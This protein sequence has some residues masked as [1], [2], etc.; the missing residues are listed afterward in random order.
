MKIK[1]SMLLALCLGSVAF[2]AGT[3]TPQ[4]APAPT[5]KTLDEID[6]SISNTTAAVKIA[7]PRTPISSTPYSITKSGSYYLTKNLTGGALDIWVDNVTI[8]LKGF[9]IIRSGGTAISLRG[10]TKK[11]IHVY[12]GTISAP[13][14]NGIDFS[15]SKKG[16]NGLLENL[17]VYDCSGYGIAVGS[18]FVIRK[19]QV[20]NAQFGIGVYRSSTVKDCTITG[21]RSSGLSTMGSGAYIANN[22]VKENKNNYSFSL[23]NHLNLV[24]SEVP[25]SLDWPCSVR[26]AG[27]LT[28]TNTDVDG[29]TINADNITI[30]MAG[31]AL[32]G[33]GTS[34]KNGIFQDATFKNLRVFNG[35]ISNWKGSIACGICAKGKNNILTNI[36]A[37]ENSTGIHSS[38]ASILSK[39]AAYKNSSSGISCGEGSTI[40]HCTA[41]KNGG[42]GIFSAKASTVS[43]CT[44]HDNG[45][46]GLFIYEGSTLSKCTAY[47]NG[48]DG[49]QAKESTITG[50]TSR[51]NKGDGIV[52]SKN[53]LVKGNNCSYNENYG[54]QILGAT[55]R[56][57][58]NTAA[59]NFK[60]IG[61]AYSGNIIVRN[62]ASGNTNSNYSTVSGS[63]IGTIRTT[64]VGAGAWDNF[65]F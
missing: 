21:C 44:A 60:G 65:S 23:D 30:D 27:T 2:G 5:M 7:E 25:Q 53:S 13:N 14:G 6:Q 24:L 4:G 26:F 32:V 38:Y 62:T 43:M 35:K 9:S 50:C 33:P 42:T 58:E 20:H 51:Y 41:Y 52:V 18:G 37:S 1:I 57:D 46:I 10:G 11:N 15:V 16:A 3:L 28:S 22:I 34:S 12:N 17:R 8:D 59:K 47:K 55:S 64:P 63:N 40:N 29:I 56:V 54:I 49:I 45:M 61:S 39:C 31:H 19:V 36:Q 48:E